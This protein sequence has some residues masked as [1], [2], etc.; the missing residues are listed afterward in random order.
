MAA[1]RCQ[2]SSEKLWSAIHDACRRHAVALHQ[3]S[4]TKGQLCRLRSFCDHEVTITTSALNE[5]E[6]T[7]LNVHGKQT[8]QSIHIERS[9]ILTGI[10][11]ASLGALLANQGH[12][13]WGLLL[14]ILGV[15][16][17]VARNIR[18]ELADRR[19]RETMTIIID[20]IR[21]VGNVQQ[22][23]PFEIRTS[24]IYSFLTY[25]LMAMLLS[26]VVAIILGTIVG[27]LAFVIMLLAVTSLMFAR[28]QVTS[29]RGTLHQFHG[30]WV[31]T[32]LCATFPVFCVVGMG[33]AV[34][35]RA[36]EPGLPDGG[37]LPD[38][39]DAIMKALTDPHHLHVSPQQFANDI[40]SSLDIPPGG[41]TF[42]VL[43]SA[44]PAVIALLLIVSGFYRAAGHLQLI[45]LSRTRPSHL[46]AESPD[47]TMNAIVDRMLLVV[48]AILIGV[49]F[50]SMT[51]VAV[52]TLIFAVRGDSLAFAP[53]AW[54][55]ELLKGFVRSSAFSDI[56]PEGLVTAILACFALPPMALLL[57]TICRFIQLVST[58]LSYL[59]HARPIGQP[60]INTFSGFIE[61]TCRQ[62]NMPVPRVKALETSRPVVYSQCSLI[63]LGSQIVMS[64][65]C[66]TLLHPVELK[67]LL[68]HELHHLQRDALRVQQLK[69]LS[70]LLLSPVYYLVILYDFAKHERAADAFAVKT[71]GDAAP[72]KSALI[73]LRVARIALGHGDSQAKMRISQRRI[74]KWIA[75]RNHVLSGLRLYFDESLFAAAYPPLWERITWIEGLAE[76]S[77]EVDKTVGESSK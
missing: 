2:M 29:W 10:G 32:C 51:I 22:L 13:V 68:A 52:D 74:M 5:Q 45:R 44:I 69:A 42:V 7:V 43:L 20:D 66:E 38:V 67:A 71:T 21:S 16:A 18:I 62:A 54:S 75:D 30:V 14:L 63:G 57:T 31:S 26:G 49:A 39:N 46:S 60:W 24:G 17:L 37:A 3:D 53:L 36:L 61:Q 77:D 48:N 40:L 72:L 58:E 23:D 65:A 6:Q 11:T 64:G 1:F 50:W 73:K 4:E 55:I 27:T 35:Y 8:T 41:P 70:L 12:V 28:R 76:T 19:T 34:R 47:S 25:P 33:V 9:L 59:R 56:V 15:S